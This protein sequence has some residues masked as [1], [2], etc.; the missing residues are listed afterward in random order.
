MIV[1]DGRIGS[2][3]LIGH[4]RYWQV[5]CQVDRL[6][7]GDVAFVGNGPQGPMAIGVEVKKVPDALQCM[8]DGRFAGHQLPGLM[9]TYDRS[10]LVLEGMFTVDFGT[11]ILL[12]GRQRRRE[13]FA[14]NAG[15]FM[16]RELDNWL[17]TMEVCGGVKLRRTA[18][19][20]ETARFICDL[21]GWWSKPWDDHKA[22]QAIH[23]ETTPYAQFGGRV[24]VSRMVAMQ[25]PGVGHDKS[26]AVIK[27]LPTVAAMAAATV[28]Q[29][30]GIEGIGPTLARRIHDAIHR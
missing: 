3:D 25:L 28:E 16:Y 4:L 8:R 14:N 22:H 7:F 5:A 30:E 6:E 12:V 23:T 19:R 11:G 20:V 9:R 27:A 29:W 2:H 10:W 1:V 15:R 17:T 26:L 24:P 18:D 13:A 21:Y